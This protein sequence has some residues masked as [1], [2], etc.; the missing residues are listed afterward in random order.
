MTANADKYARQGQHSSIVGWNANLYTHY[1]NQY[2][3]LQEARNT[4]RSHYFSLGYLPKDSTSHHRNTCSFISIAT[5]FIIGRNWKQLRC[6]SVDEW[7]MKTWYLYTV[8]Y[9]SA[10]KNYEICYK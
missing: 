2:G 4:S 5:L 3:G 6:P 10:V 8:E 1:R 9:Y 7:I